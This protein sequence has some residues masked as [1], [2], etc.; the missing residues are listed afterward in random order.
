MEQHL[1]WLE[2]KLTDHHVGYKIGMFAAQI[3]AEWGKKH[4]TSY[5][6]NTY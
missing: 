1:N 6:K 2:K 4:V 3:V 5:M